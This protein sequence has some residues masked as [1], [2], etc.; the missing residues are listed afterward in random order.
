MAPLGRISTAALTICAIL[1]GSAR[2]L[3]AQRGLEDEVRAAYL[4]NFIQFVEWPPAAFAAPSSPFRVCVYGDGPFG[5]A[6]ERTIRGEQV[7]GRPLTYEVVAPGASATQ[8]HLLFVPQ[9]QASRVAAALRAAGSGPVLLVG[10]SPNFLSAGGT[11]NL[12]VEGGRM[13]FDVNLSAAAA[14]GLVASSKLLRI[15]RNTSEWEER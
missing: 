6:L 13:R 1:Y 15:A 10:E 2:P 14:R 12:F 5:T 11:I 3:I 9:S 7:Q 8:C 4:Y